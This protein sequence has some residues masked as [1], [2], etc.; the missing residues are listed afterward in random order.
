M[1]PEECLK[2][3]DLNTALQLLQEVVRKNPASSEHR[4]FLFQLLSIL[5]QWDRALTQLNVAADL[6]AGALAMKMMYGQVLNCE[7]LREKVFQGECETVVFGKPQEWVALLLQALKLSATGEIGKSDEVRARAFEDAPSISGEIDGQPFDWIADA[8]S[9]L[10]PV[11]EAVIE[12]RYLWI[13]FNNIKSIVIEP[14]EDLRDMVWIPAHFDWV[15]GGESY[16]LIPT[17]YPE[18]YRQSD[19]LIALSRKTEW[20]E[21]SQDLFVGYGQKLLTTNSADYPIL[22]V[23]V[24]QLNSP[25][26]DEGSDG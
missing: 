12:G 13:P 14:P 7:A 18:S 20:E 24:I 26:V 2:Q 16:G 17:R 5:G 9:R 10:G 4:V 11:M 23:R 25:D 6:D 1:T 22:D 15:N 19:P 21:L 3:G 8:D